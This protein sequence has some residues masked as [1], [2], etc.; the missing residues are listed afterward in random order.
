M[1]IGTFSPNKEKTHYNIIRLKKGGESFEIVLKDADKALEFRHGKL[2]DMRDILETPK[3]FVDANTG[4]AQGA[5]KLT[6]WLGT[7]D[8]HEAAKII[9]LKGELAFTQE[10][11]K[12]MFEAKKKKIIEYIHMNASDPKTGMPHPIT[13]IEMAMEQARVQ[14]DPY[15]PAEAQIEPIIKQ[16]RAILPISFEKFRIR[17]TIPAKYSSTAYS[18]IKHKFALENERWKDDGAVEFVI[19]GPAGVK[20]DV[21][22]LIN[23][24]TTGEATIEDLKK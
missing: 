5:A 1:P 3:I 14:I 10:Q 22:T 23:K 20:P 24:L 15:Q 19:E 8:I 11:R 12:K 7:T 17:V 21:F 16:L 4:E 18:P 9:V 6:Q 13:R 2:V